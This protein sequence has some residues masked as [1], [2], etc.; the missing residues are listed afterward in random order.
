MPLMA[1]ALIEVVSAH[2]ERAVAKLDDV[3]V[4]IETDPARAEREADALRRVT[5]VPLP[6]LLWY[7]PGPPALLATTAV[8]GRQLCADDDWSAVGSALAALHAS[9]TP[10]ADDVT[11]AHTE[12]ANFPMYMRGYASWFRDHRADDLPLVE[13]LTYAAAAFFAENSG[14]VAFIHGDLQPDHVFIDSG[15]VSGVIDWADCGFGD[16]VQ[17][18]AVLTVDSPHQLDAVLRGYGGS[19]DRTA[20][21]AY[22]VLRRFGTIHW[23]NDHGMPIEADVAA[24]SALAAEG[25]F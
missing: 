3:F 6:E 12:V 25:S 19:V 5:A 18:I 17:D 20:V 10:T 7:R 21:W 11:R 16:P 1:K 4:K 23:R 24:L 8:I 9:I 13:R 2:R 15:T 14:R 22:W